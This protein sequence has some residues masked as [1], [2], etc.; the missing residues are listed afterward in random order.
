MRRVAEEFSRFA[1]SYS[2]H[3]LIQA[4][5]A[6]KLIAMLPES[7]Y[8]SILDLGCGSGE[9]YRHLKKRRITYDHMT[10]MD[11]SPE[12]LELHPKEINLSLLEGDFSAPDFIHSLP[13]H[14]YDLLISSSAL[15]WSRDLERTL[16][17]FSSLSEKIYLS[18]FTAGTFRALHEY[19]GI[20]S[21]IRSEE[22]VKE[23]IGKHLDLEFEKVSYTLYFDSVYQMLRYIKESGI[24][25][26]VQRIEY[27]ETKRLLNRYE[28]RHL[29]FEVLFAYSKS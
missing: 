22:R 25:G 17:V 11:I 23:M 18:F 29:E 13:L 1:K 7:S 28:D 5:V 8:G 26:G 24:S 19:V 6:K 16:S 27:K 21:P 9:L 12:M 15:Q 3:N 14:H 10:A 20:E 4:E 2:K